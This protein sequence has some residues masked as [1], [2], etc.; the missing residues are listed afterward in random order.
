MLKALNWTRNTLMANFV[1]L[2]KEGK[3]LVFHSG[4]Y[5]IVTDWAVS[6]K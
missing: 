6:R 1:I 2:K 4:R 5:D 3:G